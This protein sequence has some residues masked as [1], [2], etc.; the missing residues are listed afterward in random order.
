MH[1]N[2]YA[3]SVVCFKLEINRLRESALD[4]KQSKSA[5]RLANSSKAN[6]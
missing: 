5:F 2:I 4:L 6:T 1:I 3:I